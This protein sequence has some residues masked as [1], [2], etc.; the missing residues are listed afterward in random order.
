[1]CLETTILQLNLEFYHGERIPI[2]QTNWVVRFWLIGVLDLKTFKA[3][4][5]LLFLFL[6]HALVIAHQFH[7]F[8]SAARTISS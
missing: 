6:I 8:P 3:Y 4:F 7:A 5:F 1:M 2:S